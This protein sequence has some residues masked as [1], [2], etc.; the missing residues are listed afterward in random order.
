MKTPTIFEAETLVSNGE[1]VVEIEQEHV[2]T[3]ALGITL[4]LESLAEQLQIISINGRERV[5][6]MLQRSDPSAKETIVRRVERGGCSF[7]IATT[8]AQCLQAMLL[9]AYRDGVAEVNHMHIEGTLG[10]SGFDL[11]FFFKSSQPPMSPAE[12]E[13]LMR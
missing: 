9:R 4:L 10:E 6:L 3:W 2:G 1:I 7:I 8:Q 5:L 11:T 12:A 13:R